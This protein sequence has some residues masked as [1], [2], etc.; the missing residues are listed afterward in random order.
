MRAEDFDR[1]SIQELQALANKCFK[2]AQSP[3]EEP[4]ASAFG[5]DDAGKLR[6]LLEVQ[7]YLTAVARKRD[8]TVANRDFWLEIAVIVLIAGEIILSIVGICIAVREGKQQAR[9][10]SNIQRST[11]ETAGAMSA[12]RQSLESLRLSQTQS[13]DYLKQMDTNLQSSQKATSAMASAARKQLRILQ[14]EQTDR[15]AR[16]AKKPKFDLYLGA[17]PMSKAIGAKIRPRN[18]TDTSMSYDFTLVNEGDAIAT[19]PLLRIVVPKAVTLAPTTHIQQGPVSESPESPVQAHLFNLENVRP[20]N[21]VPITTTFQYPTDLELF[22]VDFTVDSDELGAGTP[23][24]G[25]DLVPSR[26]QK[27]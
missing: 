12:A 18:E 3:L 27:R 4:E 24:T 11:S 26:F 6:L 21:R 9:V 25:I 19:K 23:L 20:G 5:L 2:M 1:A 17:T 13:R 8:E 10:F 22:H 15:L 7:F 16:V 14:A